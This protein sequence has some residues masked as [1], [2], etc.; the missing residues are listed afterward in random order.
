MPAAGHDIEIVEEIVRESAYDGNWDTPRLTH[1]D[2][3]FAEW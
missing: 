3:S 2:G 1:E